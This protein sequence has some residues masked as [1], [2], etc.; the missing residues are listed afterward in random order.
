MEAQ[1]ACAVALKEGELIGQTQKLGQHAS[2]RDFQT[3]KVKTQ[4]KAKQQ[5]Y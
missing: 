2:T 4:T 5:K 1:F 3:S